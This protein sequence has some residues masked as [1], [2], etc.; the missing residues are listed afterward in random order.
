MILDGNEHVA[1]RAALREIAVAVHTNGHFGALQIV[2]VAHVHFCQIVRLA[3]L[4][5]DFALKETEGGIGPAGAATVLVLHA[6]D[7]QL[8]DDGEY[9]FV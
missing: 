5:Q 9:W 8:L 4:L 6:G 2:F 3:G 1:C 7:R